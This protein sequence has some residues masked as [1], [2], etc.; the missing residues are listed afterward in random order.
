MENLP[1]VWHQKM[2]TEVSVILT[3]EI[4]VELTTES[5]FLPK[6]SINWFV[7]PVS[8][9]FKVLSHQC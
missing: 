3:L 6:G 9:G 2:E 1:L 5:V 7:F 4:V 8:I